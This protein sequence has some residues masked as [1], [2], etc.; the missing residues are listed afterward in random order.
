[1]EYVKSLNLPIDQAYLRIP[2]FCKQSD[3]NSRYFQVKLTRGGEIVNAESLGTVT[4]VAIGIRRPDGTANGFLGTYENG[5]FTLPLPVWGVEIA[6]E[7]K[8][9]VMVWG[10]KDGGESYLLRSAVF[11]VSVERSAYAEDD[12]EKDESVDILTD[13]IDQVEGVESDIQEAEEDRVAAEQGRVAAE[14]ARVEAEEGR[15]EA[16][17]TR[18]A[19]ET[20]RASAEA[21]RAAAETARESAETLRV[22]AEKNRESAETGRVNAENL[23]E[24]NEVA[25]KA[26][27]TV[28]AEAET[29][30][31]DAETD[32]VEAENARAAAESERASAEAARAAAETARA[33][34][35]TSRVNAEKNRES[36]EAGR[37][38]AENLREGNEAARKAAETARAEAEDD[39]VAA[40]ASRVSAE[41]G[42]VTAESGRES[43]ETSR[44]NAEKARA[45]AESDR[46]EA[47]DD[48]VEAENARAA[49]ESARASA[50][51]ARASA[52]A[53]RAS[54][55]TSRVNA[56]K[57]RVTAETGRVNAEKARETEFDQKIQACEQ[58]TVA[59]QEVVEEAE[60]QGITGT[61]KYDKAQDLTDDQKAQARSNIGASA[62]DNKAAQTNTTTKAD[63]RVLFSNS[64]NDT[65]ETAGVRKSAKFL[66]NPNT[67]EFYAQGYRRQDITGKT[68]DLNTL[69]LS[70]GAPHSM[71]YIEKTSGGAAN[72]S[73]GSGDIPV[74]GQPFLLDVDLIRWASATDYVT[75]QIFVSIGQKNYEYIRWCTSGTW[76]GWTRRVFTDTTYGAATS[77][78]QGLVKLGSDTVQ[79][80]A[81]AAVSATASR[82]YAVQKNADGQLVVNVPWSNT[83]TKNT[84]GSTNS[85]AKL[86][87]IG[88]TSQAASP[89]TYSHDTAYIGT[90]GHLYS[91]SKQVVNLT[92]KQALTNKTY[93]GYTLAAACARGV[94]SLTS[95]GHLS[96]GSNNNY[97]I[98][99]SALTYWNGAY[100]ENGSSNLSKAVN[101]AAESNTNDIAT[102]KWVRDGVPS[103]T[104]G[105]AKVLAG[106]FLGEATGFDFNDYLFQGTSAFRVFTTGTTY[107]QDIQN[108]PPGY[109]T[110]AFSLECLPAPAG[111]AVQRLTTIDMKGSDRW[112]TQWIRYAIFSAG[113]LK[114]TSD[115]FKVITARDLV[116]EEISFELNTAYFS[117]ATNSA[118]EPLTKLYRILGTNVYIVAVSVNVISAI[119]TSTGSVWVINQFSPK[120]L[121]TFQ[122]VW[123]R[124]SHYVIGCARIN[125]GGN[126]LW[127]DPFDNMP[128]I[129]GTTIQCTMAFVG[130]N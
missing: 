107:F 74:T 19:A 125:G 34:A 84:A 63:Y 25:R 83:D 39:R 4:K 108:G 13:L 90:D 17:N 18:S 20:A 46:A 5:M 70:A 50:E 71:R 112:M 95:K 61:V 24:G 2:L 47:E 94:F 114:E 129:N 60:Q 103:M 64:A 123:K 105:Y 66:A 77:S 100:N 29:Q 102:T 85:S 97:L 76:S 67:G 3:Y 40:E 106:T 23:R 1:M 8:C 73:C 72:I 33:S 53:A 57:S 109:E 45:A 31:E 126:A 26:A 101:P 69:N 15:V 98:D 27:E 62:T 41:K 32:R 37:V 43:A 54:A 121:T 79:N 21:A 111:E 59:A 44:V 28:R 92:D 80:V 127:L 48:R 30:R 110:G 124:S 115:W 55:E 51:A 93:N 68:L 128:T 35:E 78:A 117:H 87:L 91:N 96:Y 118:G 9:D 7:I 86:F 16:E 75:R 12:A 49:A 56:E 6:G 14:S 36:A 120:G 113:D 119:T 65:T 22:N 42:R 99:K 116:Q 11:V 58:A 81:A 82:T 88:A 130:T 104:A 52:E 38:N 122:S 89:Q 10:K